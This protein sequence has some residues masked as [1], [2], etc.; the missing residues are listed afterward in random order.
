MLFTNVRSIINKRDALS[1]VID[2]G[3]ADVI[4]RSD[5]WLHPQV[6]DH[7]IPHQSRFLFYRCDRTIR[8]G[9]GV[10]LG[11]SK[12]FLSQRIHVISPLEI[13]CAL[14]EIGSRKFIICSC[15]RPPTDSSDFVN[16]LND[17]LNLLVSRYPT[18]PILL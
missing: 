5:A 14:V 15:Y 11:V 7:E 10:L 6:R 12:N 17:V 8:R 1:S 4:I 3:N 13:A 16:E 2:T 9:G 18:F